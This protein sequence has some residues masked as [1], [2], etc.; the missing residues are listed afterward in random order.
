MSFGDLPAVGSE[1]SRRATIPRLR[2]PASSSH[3]RAPARRGRLRRCAGEDVGS[4]VVAMPGE[5]GWD[6]DQIKEEDPRSPTSAPS[7]TH[8][9]TSAHPRSRCGELVGVR[10]GTRPGLASAGSATGVVWPHAMTEVIVPPLFDYNPQRRAAVGHVPAHSLPF[11]RARLSRRLIRRMSSGDLPAV[12]SESFNRRHRFPTCESRLRAHTYAHHRLARGRLR[13]CAG[14]ND[15]NPQRRAA[16]GHVPVPS[17]QFQ[18][19][20]VSVV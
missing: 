18:R 8:A 2:V 17:L 11:H 4:S 1:A 16:V 7:R 6:L 5:P 12:G 20:R 9:T 14:E 3:V 19:A 13:R 10:E 15:Y